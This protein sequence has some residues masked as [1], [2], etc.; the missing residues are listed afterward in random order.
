MGRIVG[1]EGCSPAK[2][3]KD[4]KKASLL[5]KGGRPQLRWEDYVKGEDEK[6]RENWR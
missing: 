1:A 4:D 2:E 3:S 5:K 6:L